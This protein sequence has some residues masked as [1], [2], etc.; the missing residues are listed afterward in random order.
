MASVK[1]EDCSQT[2]ELNVNIKDEEE[3]IG[4]SV[5][6]GKSRFYLQV[7]SIILTHTSP[8]SSRLLFISTSNCVESC[9]RTV[10]YSLGYLEC[11]E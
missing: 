5:Y 4:E 9:C 1:L 10:F 2:L 7:D 8:K 11:S 6:D 3:K